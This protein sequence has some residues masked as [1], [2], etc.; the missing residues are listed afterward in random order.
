[1]ST[2]LNY[3]ASLSD[4]MSVGHIK[5]HRPL[6]IQTKHSVNY[7]DSYGE[8]VI[9]FI[10]TIKLWQMRAD[11]NNNVLLLQHFKMN[12]GCGWNKLASQL[13]LNL[14]LYYA[15]KFVRSSV[16]HYSAVRYVFP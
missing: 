11:F 12:C 6:L 2:A 13:C 5:I 9:T 16:D 4:N 10:F 15:A 14:L 8:G 1:M 7:T 3:H